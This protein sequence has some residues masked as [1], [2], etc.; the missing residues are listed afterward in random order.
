MKCVM[1]GRGKQENRY[2]L[3]SPPTDHGDQA[4]TAVHDADA[5][6]IR[7]LACGILSIIFRTP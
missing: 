1:F 3:K 7:Q 4:E 5:L 6:E 2:P